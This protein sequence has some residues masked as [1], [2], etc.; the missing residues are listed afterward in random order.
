MN[1][2]LEPE[3][4]KTI[5]SRRFAFERIGHSFRVTEFEAALGLA[6][7]EDWKEMIE[8][9]RQNANYLTDLLAPL[10]DYLQLPKIRPGATHSFMMYPLVLKVDK[11]AEVTNYL[12]QNGI[13]TRDMLPILPQPVYQKTL[14]VDPKD[15]PNANYVDKHGFYIGC[16]SSV[17]FEHAGRLR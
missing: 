8:I 15:F 1:T 13:E 7:M 3:E 16:H 4:L 2:G 9:R 14:G 10:S 6:A 11:K 12:E 17:A 5:I